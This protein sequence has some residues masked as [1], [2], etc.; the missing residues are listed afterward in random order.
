MTF[1]LLIGTVGVI[2]TLFFIKPLTGKVGSNHKLVHKLKDTKWFQNHWLAGMFLFIVNAVLFFSTGLIL[3]VFVLTY[4]LI[5]YVHLFIMLF[6][7]IVSIFL[8][9]LIYKAWQGTKINR[10]KMGF[11]GSSFYIVLTVIFVYW[12]LT[13]KPS[14]PGDDTF[15]GAIGLLFSIIVTSVAF[16]TCFVITGFYKNENKQRIDI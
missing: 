11:I 15:M 2:L 4:F 7:A 9:I 14:Y 1:I 12:L 6:A 16:I 13:L 10:L 5:P 8:W 3:Y